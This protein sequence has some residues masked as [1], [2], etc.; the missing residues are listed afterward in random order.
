MEELH[1]HRT[2]QEEIHVCVYVPAQA[3]AVCFVY[4]RYTWVLVRALL[5]VCCGSCG[6]SC[7]RYCMS[8]LCL[9]AS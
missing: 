8:Y 3:C 9:C 1:L 5:Y 2:S 7:Y 6:K 4:M